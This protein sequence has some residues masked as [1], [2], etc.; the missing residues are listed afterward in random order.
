MDKRTSLPVG[1]VGLSLESPSDT[2][3]EPIG[4]LPAL[5]RSPEATGDSSE[6]NGPCSRHSPILE[7]PSPGVASVTKAKRDGAVEVVW[8]GLRATENSATGPTGVELE[9]KVEE[10]VLEA[11][12][13]RQGPSS[14]ELP[15][16]VKEGRGVVEVV[17][18][19]LGGSDLDATAGSARTPQATHT[20][21][22]KL[23]EQFEAETSRKDDGASRDSPE[24]VGREGPGGEEGSFIW[25][26]RGAFSEDWE[27]LLMEGLEAPRG[28]GGAGG[29]ETLTGS[30]P[31]EGEAS[32]EVERREVEKSEGMKEKGQIC[33]YLSWTSRQGF[34]LQQ[35]RV[36]W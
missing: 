5:R 1:P 14:P 29:P 27:E 21:S 4:A 23:Q 24:G 25:V 31:R 6:A 26:E 11:I 20:S 12:G 9:A 16:W 19:G 28:V 18:E 34:Q 13:A 36:L 30:Q 2:R 7:Q 10:V 3:E 35:R 15:T 33:H 22:P 17:W 8:A 32:W